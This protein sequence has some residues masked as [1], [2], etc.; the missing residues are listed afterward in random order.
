MSKN[1]QGD[2]FFPGVLAFSLV[3]LYL[4]SCKW[5]QL[6]A[7]GNSNFIFFFLNFPTLWFSSLPLAETKVTRH[8]C[9]KPRPLWA[10]ILAP[11]SLP[12]LATELPSHHWM[13]QSQAIQEAPQSITFIIT[14]ASL[15]IPALLP[16]QFPSFWA[17][18]QYFPFLFLG[19]APIAGP[20]TS[21]QLL[22]QLSPGYLV[23]QFL[24]PH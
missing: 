19:S 24:E 17:E 10:V 7:T 5:L 1:R 23:Q 14:S 6:V 18:R 12:N 21:A 11:L 2:P 3:R 8:W 20:I 13:E 16:S 4:L 9:P 15:Y 22:F